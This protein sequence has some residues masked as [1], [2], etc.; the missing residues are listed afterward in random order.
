MWNEKCR[1]GN[2]DVIPR[3]TTCPWPGTTL[4]VLKLPIYRPSDI[5]VYETVKRLLSASSIKR[6]AKLFKG[7]S[8]K[9]TTLTDLTPKGEVGSTFVHQFSSEIN[10]AFLMSLDVRPITTL[11]E[12]SKICK[13]G[14][15]LYGTPGVMNPDQ[16]TS[17][18]TSEDERRIQPKRMITDHHAV[19]AW[20]QARACLWAV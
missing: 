4:Q 5:R 2:A 10:D 12:R 20:S 16:I 14:K 8:K 3:A 6:E 19:F 17:L 13:A 15:W 9:A 1:P 11:D 7:K 18:L